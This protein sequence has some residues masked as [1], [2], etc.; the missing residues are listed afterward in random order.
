MQQFFANNT[1]GLKNRHQDQ[2][3]TF[4]MAGEE[5][6]INIL[7][8]MEI[9]GYEK[10]TIIPGCP[11]CV[12]GVI[13]LRGKIIPIVDLRELLNLGSVEYDALTVVII[14]QLEVEQEKYALGL[15]VDSVSD[16]YT[17]DKEQLQM[18]PVSSNMIDRNFIEGLVNVNN[19]MIVLLSCRHLL[20][21]PQLTKVQIEKQFEQQ[22][23]GVSS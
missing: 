18:P 1:S 11:P 16:V 6:G 10:P 8:V 22:A 20:S 2:Y 7:S 17:V 5:Y 19:K 4:H 13:D 12:K 9:R 3:L 14:M 15:I 23:T 21:I